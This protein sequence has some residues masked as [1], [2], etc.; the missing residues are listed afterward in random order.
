[1]L[2]QFLSPSSNHRTDRYDGLKK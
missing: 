2:H 1:M